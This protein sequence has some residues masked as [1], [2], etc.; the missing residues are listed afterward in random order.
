MVTFSVALVVC[1]RLPLTPWIVSVK[2]PRTPPTVCTLS[3]E[4]VV[5]GLGAQVVSRQA[6]VVT[7]GALL[8]SSIVLAAGME[9]TGLDTV[10]LLWTVG[11]VV[12]ARR[13][14]AQ[15]VV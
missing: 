6:G 12:L 15:A 1:V 10:G 4:L 13:S 14:I 8:G 11:V 7:A 2:L 3:V 9:A 5:A